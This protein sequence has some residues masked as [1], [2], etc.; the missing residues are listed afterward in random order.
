[1]TEAPFHYKQR[2]LENER[3]VL[4]PFDVRIL[5]YTERIMP[6]TATWTN[7]PNCHSRYEVI[8]ASPELFEYVPF[9]AIDS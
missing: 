7:K 4:E 9:P 3:L 2:R 1:M 5:A 8:R 6:E